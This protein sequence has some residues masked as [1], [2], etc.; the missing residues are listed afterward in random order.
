MGSQ[1]SSISKT[2]IK[3]DDWYLININKIDKQFCYIVLFFQW[4]KLN[5]TEK[6]VDNLLL[7]DWIEFY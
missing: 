1:R 7:I 2:K 4:I 3:N 6:V 5:W